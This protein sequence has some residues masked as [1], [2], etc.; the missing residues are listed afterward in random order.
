[1]M[2]WYSEKRNVGESDGKSCVIERDVCSIDNMLGACPDIDVR[3][4]SGKVKI[5]M[6]N[7][8]TILFFKDDTDLVF[9]IDFTPNSGKRGICTYH[10]PLHMCWSDWVLV[11]L[12][13]AVAIALFWR[14]V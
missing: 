3:R 4:L 11:V 12:L 6:E 2:N 9:R 8:D 14:G 1:M 13:V 5:P 7:T 10:V